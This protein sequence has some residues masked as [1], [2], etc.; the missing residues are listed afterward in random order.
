MTD[1]IFSR[2]SP[3]NTQRGFKLGM[4]KK[5][6]RQSI[7]KPQWKEEPKP[8]GLRRAARSHTD[9]PLSSTVVLVENGKHVCKVKFHESNTLQYIGNLMPQGIS[10]FKPAY[11]KVVWREIKQMY[12]VVCCYMDHSA[13]ILL[14]E[15][16]ERP[17][18]VW[19]TRTL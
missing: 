6:A 11:L 4:M 1:R 19:R 12:D 18:W 9:G 16:K 3:A 10:H 17:D 14:W 13:C 2:V 15:T 8:L 5:N 7:K